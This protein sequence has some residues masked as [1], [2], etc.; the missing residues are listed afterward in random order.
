MPYKDP[1]ARR[2]W[3]N[4]WYAKN[5]RMRAVDYTEAMSEW[6]ANHPE[7]IAAHTIL[8]K[9][10][11]AGTIIKPNKCS[12]CH[13]IKRLSAHHNNYNKPLEIEWLCSSCHKLK[14]PITKLP[15]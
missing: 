9:A 5:G 11:R 15:Y 2:D 8:Q 13:K 4:K 3:Y 14:H 6:K 10:V 7:A 12:Q 1:Q